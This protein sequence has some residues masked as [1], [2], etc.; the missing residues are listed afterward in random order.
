MNARDIIAVCQR[1]IKLYPNDCSR[2]VRSVGQDCGIFLVGDA[3]AIVSQLHYTGRKLADGPAAA[4]AARDGELVIGGLISSGHGHVV[5]VVDGPLNRGKY[6]YAFW[7]KYKGFILKTSDEVI[8]VGYTRGHG[9]I[10]Y[11][12]IP[13]QRDKVIYAAYK[14]VESIIPKA[15]VNEGYLIHTFI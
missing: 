3:N 11:A 4:K 13:A 2:F 12:W 8:N 7:G 10:N 15:G 9:T 1:N 5:V 6:P 14:P